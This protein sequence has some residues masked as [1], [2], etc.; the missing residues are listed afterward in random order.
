MQPGVR[1]PFFFLSQLPQCNLRHCKTRHGQ[2]VC[3]TKGHSR[4]T[5]GHWL[6]GEPL[7]Q[8]PLTLKHILLDCADFMHIRTKF[9]QLSSDQLRLENCTQNWGSGS[10]LSSADFCQ[11]EL[12]RYRF[13][14]RRMSTFFKL[15]LLLHILLDSFETRYP[16]FLG[17]SPNF[18]IFRI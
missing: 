4:F 9:Y 5:H 14:W 3:N 11:V 15:L 6:K 1:G 12:I 8:C 17:Q 10:F 18:V 2:G 13:V 7:C 16:Y